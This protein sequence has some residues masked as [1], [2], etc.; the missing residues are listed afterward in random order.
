MSLLYVDASYQGIM[1]SV[2][3]RGLFSDPTLTYEDISHIVC[4]ER[5]DGSDSTNSLLLSKKIKLDIALQMRSSSNNVPVYKSNIKLCDKACMMLQYAE[6][7][8]LRDN[9]SYQTLRRLDSWSCRYHDDQ[10][11]NKIT[12]HEIAFGPNAGGGGG[13]IKEYK[14]R[15]SIHQQGQ[16]L[17][18]TNETA[19]EDD[20]GITRV[21]WFNLPRGKYTLAIQERIS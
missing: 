13:M 18:I 20:D 7:A 19:S 11:R 6:F 10:L 14:S 17:A 21:L 4:N 1:D 5:A 16:A 15:R 8:V 12:V 9:M 2:L 3:N